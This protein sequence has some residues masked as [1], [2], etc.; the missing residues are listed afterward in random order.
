MSHVRTVEVLKLLDA[1]ADVNSRFGF[2][3]C[4]P[5]LQAAKSNRI[6]VPEQCDCNMLLTLHVLV[7][8][9]LYVLPLICHHSYYC[10]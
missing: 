9:A 8:G 2:D 5:L 1:G 6:E 10:H 4:I 7:L 3:K